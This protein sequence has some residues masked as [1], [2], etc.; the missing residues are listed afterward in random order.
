MV[1]ETKLYDTL[2]IKPGATQDEIKKGY[3]SSPSLW[4]LV[5]TDEWTGSLLS[6]PDQTQT[7]STSTPIDPRSTPPLTHHTRY[8]PA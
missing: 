5:L 4:W 1:R 6:P 8:A 2:S 7:T 3:S